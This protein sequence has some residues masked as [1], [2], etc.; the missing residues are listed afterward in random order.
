[1]NEFPDAIRALL[2]CPACHGPLEDRMGGEGKALVCRQCSLQY[3]VR[4]GIPVLLIEQAR[5]ITS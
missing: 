3:P 1:V 2:A 5:S 4:E